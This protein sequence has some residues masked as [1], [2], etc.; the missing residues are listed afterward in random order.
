MLRGFLLLTALLQVAQANTCVEEFSPFDCAG[1]SVCTQWNDGCNDCGCGEANVPMCTMKMC[2]CLEDDSCVPTCKDN[3]SCV[4]KQEEPVAEPKASTEACTDSSPFDCPDGTV[5]TEWNDGCNEC[6]CNEGA[7]V[8]FCT[9]MM[10][11]CLED[12]SCVPTC[13]DNAACVPKEVEVAVSVPYIANEAGDTP[14][15]PTCTASAPFDCPDGTVCTEWNDGCNECG[16]NAGADVAFC[17]MMMCPCLEDN[18]CVPTCK[19]NAACVPENNDSALLGSTAATRDNDI[20]EDDFMACVE[21]APFDCPEGTYC[22]SWNDGCNN[23]VCQ[24]EGGFTSSAMACPWCEDGSEDCV[25]TC[26]DN[27][28][29]VPKDEGAKSED[30]VNQMINSDAFLGNSGAN[31]MVG[32]WLSAALAVLVA[33]LG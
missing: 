20:A 32:L 14:A 25:P 16:C 10:C 7:D 27:P 33:V 28:E 15:E 19:D 31:S 13:K 21:D 12:N 22:T 11:P 29:C 18:S 2:P 9:Y 1:Y 8:A 23:K 3:P 5:C 30:A 4:P 26:T 24:E 17:T 6:G